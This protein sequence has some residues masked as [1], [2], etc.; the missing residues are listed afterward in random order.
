[1]KAASGTSSPQQVK[2][3]SAI[4]K[5]MQGAAYN[6]F[7][8][9]NQNRNSSYVSKSQVAHGSIVASSGAPLTG[10]SRGKTTN[11]KKR[12]LYTSVGN[13]YQSQASNTNNQSVHI[14]NNR[15]VKR[16]H[17]NFLENLEQTNMLLASN[18]LNSSDMPKKRNKSTTK[19]YNTKEHLEQA[20]LSYSTNFQKKVNP[21]SSALADISQFNSNHNSIVKNF[22]SSFQLNNLVPNSSKANQIATSKRPL[23]SSKGNSTIGQKQLKKKQQHIRKSVNPQQHFSNLANQSAG[24]YGH[25]Q[26]AYDFLV[27][28]NILMNNSSKARGSK[29]SNIESRCSNKDQSNSSVLK[30]QQQIGNVSF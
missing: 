27:N 28:A 10:G 23:S 16:L 15:A 6:N 4:G 2:S 29:G 9:G 8:N 24:S 26:N 25:H 12:N 17:N 14:Q 13:Y 1:M 5:Y 30:N 3:R 19:S 11:R 18:Q 22:D 7:Y 21:M 20:D